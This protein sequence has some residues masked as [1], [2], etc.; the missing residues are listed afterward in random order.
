[1]AIALP[2]R[3]ED[4]VAATGPEILEPVARLCGQVAQDDRA[5]RRRVQVAARRLG[6]QF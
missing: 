4:D 2:T 5:R 1:M 6:R 3:R